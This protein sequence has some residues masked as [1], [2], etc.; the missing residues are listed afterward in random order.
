VALLSAPERK[1][2]CQVH[3]YP[4][5]VLRASRTAFGAQ[6]WIESY[7]AS[8]V[9]V[10]VPAT[11]ALPSLAQPEIL[12]RLIAKLPWGHTTRVLTRVKGRHLEPVRSQSV[13]LQDRRP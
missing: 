13:L 2:P 1:P 8:A 9:E 4:I 11:R 7:A 12:Q 10:S 6:T 5:G 3:L